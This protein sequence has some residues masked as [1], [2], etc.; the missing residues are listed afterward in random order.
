MAQFRLR[1]A[2]VAKSALLILLLGARALAAGTNTADAWARDAFAPPAANGLAPG[3][4][5]FATLH[6]EVVS[7]QLQVLWTPDK[8]LGSNADVRII[9]STDPPGHWPA[10]DWRTM[11][12]HRHGTSWQANVPTDSVDVPVA[13]CVLIA[14]NG[15]RCLSS[16]R[17]CHPRSLGLE[18]PSRLFWAFLEGF[19]QGLESWRVLGGTGPLRTSAKARS[20]RNALAVQIAPQGRS[21]TVATSRLRGWYAEEHSARGL[22]FWAR[23]AAGTAQLRCSLMADAFTTNQV[24]VAVTNT[25]Q[26]APAWKR[27]EILFN[28]FPQLVIGALDL[29]VFEVTGD[30]GTELELDDLYLIGRWRRDKGLVR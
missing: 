18:Q 1:S 3:T 22:A 11:P 2:A 30:A 9:T 13:Y 21:A 20:G 14:E 26:L 29:V 23:T 27:F 4:N 10:R 17:V 15:D 25:M 19:E 8:I 24:I 5:L 6:A 28:D 16:I 7:E 12:M